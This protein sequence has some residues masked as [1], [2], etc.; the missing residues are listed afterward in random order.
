MTV[1]Y[2][3]QPVIR[4]RMPYCDVLHLCI[5]CSNKCVYI[6]S[7]MRS[8]VDDPFSLRCVRVVRLVFMSL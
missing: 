4:I 8:A 3:R 7:R 2:F 6:V 1:E 5:Y